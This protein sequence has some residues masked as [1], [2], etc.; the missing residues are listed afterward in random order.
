MAYRFGRIG[1]A[2]SAIVA[3]GSDRGC[4]AQRREHELRPD[5]ARRRSRSR[6]ARQLKINSITNCAKSRAPSS[7]ARCQGNADVERQCERTDIYL[8]AYARAARHDGRIFQPARSTA[9][10][11]RTAGRT[12]AATGRAAGAGRLPGYDHAGSNRRRPSRASNKA[13]ARR[14]RRRSD[15]ARRARPGR[16]RAARRD[17]RRRARRRRGGGRADRPLFQDAPLCR[18]EGPAGGARAG[19]SRHPPRRR[20]ARIGPRR[21]ARPRR[22]RAGAAGAV[23]RLAARA[24]ADRGRRAGGAGRDRAGLAARPARSAGRRRRSAPPCSAG[25]RSIFG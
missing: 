14:P 19:L 13:A 10:R 6:R 4:N 9:R 12:A 17:P 25:R 5:R 16:D 22:G 2:A 21:D 20:S 24:G 7:E 11:R 23:R 1:A 15:D 8:R 3:A 18:I